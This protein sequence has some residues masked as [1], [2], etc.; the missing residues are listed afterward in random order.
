[1]PEFERRHGK[2]KYA[3]AWICC[4]SNNYQQG[5]K[6]RRNEPVAYLALT[7]MTRLDESERYHELLRYNNMEEQRITLAQAGEY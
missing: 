7:T 1:M 4:C 6:V 2:N 5:L 3:G